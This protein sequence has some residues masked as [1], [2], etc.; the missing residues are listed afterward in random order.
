LNYRKVYIIIK[1][2]FPKA[3]IVTDRFHV[4]QLISEAVQEVR[5][6]FRWK[7]IAEE[8]KRIK[9]AREEAFLTQAQVADELDVTI[10]TVQAWEYERANLTLRRA[11]QLARLYSVPMEWIAWGGSQPDLDAPII[12]ELKRLIER[13]E[14]HPER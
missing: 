9:Q 12:K 10:G 6:A 5:I 3:A 11:A 8:N 2:T 14:R 1:R 4:Q 13:K 7:A